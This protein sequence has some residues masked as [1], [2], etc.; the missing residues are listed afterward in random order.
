MNII[1]AFLLDRVGRKLLMIIGLCGC[2]VALVLEMIMLA[3]YEGTRNKA[4]NAAGVFFLFFHLIF[5]GSCMDGST[6]VYGSEIWPTHL[7]AK[8]FAISI[9]G[10]FV[11]SCTLLVAAPTAF[12]NIGWKFYLVLAIGT[13]I[14]IF[15]FAFFFPETKGLPLEEIAACFGDKVTVHLHSSPAVLED[16]K[17]EQT[18]HQTK[19]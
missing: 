7:R 15:I 4:G 17:E 14:N 16:D 19:N 2:V 13:F 11:S 6:Y 1:N 5:Y 9:A 18:G 3:L 8:G 10:L 12:Q